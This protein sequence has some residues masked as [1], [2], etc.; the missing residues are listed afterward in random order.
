MSG[1]ETDSGGEG[2][3]P[4]KTFR[5]IRQQW[6]SNELRNFLRNLDH[7]YRANWRSPIGS[8]ASRGNPPRIRISSKFSTTTGEV[9]PRLPRN[10]YDRDWL[11]GLRQWQKDDLDIVEEDY[12]FTI[13]DE[14]LV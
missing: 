3:G 10:C 5:I 14:E 2:V 8:R 9:P 6:M 13:D 7:I 12:D 11:A 4:P 1:D